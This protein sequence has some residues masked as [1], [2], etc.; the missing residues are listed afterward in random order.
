MQFANYW[1]QNDKNG[2]GRQCYKIQQHIPLLYEMPNIQ[3][4]KELR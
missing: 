4:E 2:N 3:T 1:K